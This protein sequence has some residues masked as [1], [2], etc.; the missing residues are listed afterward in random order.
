MLFNAIK[1]LNYDVNLIMVDWG[2]GAKSIR[3]WIPANNGRV[4]GSQIEILVSKLI[5]IE[6]NSVGD[7]HLAGHSLGAHIV[8]YA[9]K[10]YR[11]K[12]NG[13]QLVRITGLDPAGPMYQ[14]EDNEEIRKIRIDR[15]DA[16]FVDIIHSNAGDLDVVNFLDIIDQCDTKEGEFQRKYDEIDCIMR[17][18]FLHLKAF[19]IIISEVSL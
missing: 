2:A 1:D 18:Y 8:G 5:G 17:P 14:F 15:D 19:Q 10:R 3:Y 11:E 7:F 4:V 12:H 9:G 13:E 6:F 16:Y